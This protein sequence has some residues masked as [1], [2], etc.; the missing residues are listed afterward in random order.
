MNSAFDW[1]TEKSTIV[2][3]AENSHVHS[4]RKI[5]S[6]FFTEKYARVQAKYDRISGGDAE[7]FSV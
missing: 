3:Y 2:F 6:Y 5:R 1:S 7:N 4:R